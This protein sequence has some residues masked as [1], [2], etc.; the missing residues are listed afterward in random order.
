[1]RSMVFAMPQLTLSKLWN[2]DVNLKILLIEHDKYTN[3]HSEKHVE[4]QEKQFSAFILVLLKCVLFINKL[5]L[6]N[7]F[8]DCPNP[9]AVKGV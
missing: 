7:V 1:M 4:N 2:N 9:L 3:L 6:T 5:K 8:T